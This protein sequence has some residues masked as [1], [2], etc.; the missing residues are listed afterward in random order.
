MSK[1]IKLK[2]GT[3]D[4]SELVKNPKDNDF[5]AYLYSIDEKVKQ[6]ES[7]RHLLK[8]DILTKRFLELI[9]DSEHISEKLSIVLG[10]AHLKYAE[11]TSSNEA[12]AL[13]TKMNIYATEISNKLLFF[14]LWF[15]K[16]IDDNNANRLI[17]QVPKTYQEHL[18][19]ERSLSKFTLKESEEKIINILDNTGISA[20]LKIYD[21]M[22]NGFEFE[23]IEIKGKKKIKK[24]FTNK[25]KLVSL[26]RSSQPSERVA[27]YKSLWSTYK[28]NSGVLG[29]IYINRVLNWHDEYITLRKFPSP[30]SV[31]NLYNNIDDKTIETLLKVCR[32]NAIIFQNYFK[33]KSKMLKM[34]KLERYHI[35]APLKSQ[36]QQKID[37]DKAMKMVL[38][39][40]EDFDPKFKQVV[41]GLIEKKHIDS[42]LRDSKQGG[43]FCSTIT[44]K[45]DPFVLLNFDG[46]IRDIST[47]AH[48]FGH[49]IHSVLASD[50][51]ISVQHAPLPLAETAS[52]F[53]EML[54]NDKIFNSVAAR[55][56]KILLAEQIDDFY[57][58][59]MRQ[60]Y[61]TIFEVSAH[62]SISEDNATT[63]D[64]L[65]DL[66]LG[67][68]KEQFGESVK[69]T[70]D[71]KYEWL[72]IPHIYH[73]PFYCYAYSFGNLL[74]MSLYQQYKNEGKD[75]IPKYT[76]ILSSGGTKKPEDLLMDEGIDI[77]KESF[78]QKGFDLVNDKIAE[79]R[80]IK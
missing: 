48:E 75:F 55:E 43:A 18:R 73:S 29:E 57:A 79:L 13:L 34:K 65:A 42:E 47:M 21:R 31:R 9:K 77:T 41:Q 68:L 37:Y 62:D 32:S 33:E 16:E 24:I 23:Y 12:G 35:Y 17:E 25:E 58:T 63:I 74:V 14:D 70:D 3:W 45:I 30:I 1:L 53:G 59:I 78:W 8:P 22:T 80:S 28:K 10:Y 69:I 27:A 7:K 19:H 38:D 67:N 64:E 66:Y 46:T 4:L 15:K 20:L 61:F 5:S 71:F 39:A 76:R 50:K 6:F 49:A 26:V 11:D 54:L 52:V 72:Y 51:P 2:T 40:Y 44:P 56:K 36:K 60:T